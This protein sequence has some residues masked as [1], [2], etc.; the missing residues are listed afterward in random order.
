MG[1]KLNS[2]TDLSVYNP[3]PAQY[4]VQ[5][6]RH[7]QMQMHSSFSIGKGNRGLPK[8]KMSFV[9][10]PGAYNYQN[11]TLYKNPNCRFGRERRKSTTV[12]S[13]SVAPGPGAYPHKDSLEEKGVSLH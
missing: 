2:K 13:A 10:G 9:P 1:K 11:E 6:M 5:N 3:G 4:D 12:Q 7:T 8:N